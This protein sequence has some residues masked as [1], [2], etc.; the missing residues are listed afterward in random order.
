[1]TIDPIRVRAIDPTRQRNRRGIQLAAQTLQ[2]DGLGQ[3]LT[4]RQGRLINRREFVDRIAQTAKRF[5][6]LHTHDS[7][8]GVWVGSVGHRDMGIV[9]VVGGGPAEDA[10]RDCVDAVFDGS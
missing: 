8:E 9:D 6:D 5:G 2:L 7:E 1:M 10:A 4:A 3:Q